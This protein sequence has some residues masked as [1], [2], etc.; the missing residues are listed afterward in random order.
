M[1]EAKGVETSQP[2]TPKRPSNCSGR[3]QTPDVPPHGGH[4]LAEV[5]DSESSQPNTRDAPCSSSH[6][7]AEVMETEST[8]P[9]T[10]AE[11][12]PLSKLLGSDGSESNESCLA[13]FT[14]KMQELGVDTIEEEAVSNN[15]A[16]Q[17]ASESEFITVTLSRSKKNFQYD[18]FNRPQ[19]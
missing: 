14:R 4:T 1:V 5:M 18:G 8:Q 16:G 7:L 13:F 17:K 3:P 12:S 10:P 6:P 9:Q 19:Q 2:R 11:A 15:I